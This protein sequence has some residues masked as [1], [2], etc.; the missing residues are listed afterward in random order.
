MLKTTRLIYLIILVGIVS[1][2]KMAIGQISTNQEIESLICKPWT[3]KTY[4][5]DGINQVLDTLSNDRLIF[6]PDHSLELDLDDEILNAFWS[7]DKQTT[8]I[9]I[10][11]AETKNSFVMKILFLSTSDF[12]L[13]AKEEN[14]TVSKMHMVTDK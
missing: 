11:D 2:S 1:S 6:H 8:T 5:I 7:Y 14:G 12:T 13:E 4:E 10:T 9:T 3:L